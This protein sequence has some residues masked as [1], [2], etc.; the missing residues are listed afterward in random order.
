MSSPWAVVGLGNPGAK[1]AQTRHNVGAMAVADLA[2]ALDETLRP[3]SKVRCAV[4]EVRIHQ[5]RVVLAVPGSYMNE[6]GGPTRALS[7]FFKV[8]PDRL[9]VVHDEVDLPFGSMRLKFAGGDNGHNGLR[10]IRSSLGTG[11]WYRLRIGVGRGNSRSGDTAGHVLARFAGSEQAA[12]R[13]D[14]QTAGDAIEVLITDG[15]ARAQSQYNS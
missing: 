5:E 15:L 9:V 10:S 13:E 8:A 1:Y 12:L 7:D 4:A 14:L 6:S 3:K 2:R 11:D